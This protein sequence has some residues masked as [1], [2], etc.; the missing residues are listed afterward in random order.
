MSHRVIDFRIPQSLVMGVGASRRLPDILQKSGVKKVLVVTDQG[1]VK[2]GLAPVVSGLVEAAGIGVVVFDGVEPDPRIEIVAEC[3]AAFQGAGAGAIVGL[4]GGSSIDIAKVAAVVAA[5]GGQAGDYIGID[6][7]PGPGFPHFALPTT[8]GTGSEV[9]PIAVL[10]DTSAHLKK[11]IVS[12]YLYPSAAIV[13][14]ELMVSVPPSVTAYTG[15]DTL[16]HAIEAYTNRFALPFIDALALEAIRQTGRH[17]RRAVTCGIDLEARAGMAHAATLGGMC[18]GS[19]NTAAVHAMAYPLGG[20]YNVPHGLANTVLLPAVMEFNMPANID[21]FAAIAAALGEE[22]R[23]LSK[24]EAALLAIRAVKDLSLDIGIP[25]GMRFLGIPQDAIPRM[26]EGA[27]EVTRLMN[28]NPRTITVK[29]VR[30][31]YE[32]A[33]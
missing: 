4:G 19:V 23:G 30:Q 26:A 9:T 33:Y 28:N 17:L 27:I 31:I 14:P 24:R 15:M 1:I 25:Q 21:K 2:A 12:D 6:R 18:L 16:T 20:T 13:D 3:A 32:N 22:T 8:A 5:H 7:I 11:G 29:D 10:S